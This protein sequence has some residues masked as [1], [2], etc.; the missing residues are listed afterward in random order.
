M[1]LL[2]HKV[3]RTRRTARRREAR[4]DSRDTLH[5][6]HLIYQ[7]LEAVRLV[8]SELGEDFAVHRYVLL[9]ESVDELAV[10]QLFRRVALDWVGCRRREGKGRDDDA[11]YRVSVTGS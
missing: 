4:G 6:L 3:L 8:G 7:R 1:F 5:P 9:P 10:L 11:S 2:C